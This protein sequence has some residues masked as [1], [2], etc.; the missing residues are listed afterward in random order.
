M[1]IRY[2]RPLTII[3]ALFLS[4]LATDRATAQSSRPSL[5]PSILERLKVPLSI[6]QEHQTLIFQILMLLLD[7]VGWKTPAD[8]QAFIKNNIQAY[9]DAAAY[10]GASTEILQRVLRNLKNKP[11]TP[12]ERADLTRLID[13]TIAE[14]GTKKASPTSSSPK[15][16]RGLVGRLWKWLCGGC[17]SEDDHGTGNAASGVRG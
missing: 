13:A 10:M 16:F 2:L 11:L 15:S 1:N 4:A 12:T 17:G 8:R 6:Q 14:A 9:E 7:Q 3:V 5:D